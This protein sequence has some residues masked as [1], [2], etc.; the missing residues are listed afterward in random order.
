LVSRAS[1]PDDSG[2]TLIEVLATMA[3]GAILMTISVIGFQRWASAESQQG[4]AKSLQTV[5]RQSQVRAVTEGLSICVKFDVPAGTYTVYRYA[6][7][8]TPLVLI[9]GPYTLDG[10]TKF[11]SASFT[12]PN[13]ST[14]SGVTFR[15]SGTAW[16]GA[17][18][19]SR[20][21]SSKT[22]RIDVE[23][24]TGRVSLS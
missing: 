8:T 1:R 10:K 13:G 6:C 19:L 9:S 5:L 12:A 16:R 14:Q 18:V 17:V 3:V 24:L 7:D 4:A 21:D 22:Y 23:G 15:S 20:E 11:T 2:F